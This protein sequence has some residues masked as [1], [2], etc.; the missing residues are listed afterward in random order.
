MSSFFISASPSSY[1]YNLCHEY[2]RQQAASDIT[3][4]QTRAEGKQQLQCHTVKKALQAATDF[5]DA[6]ECPPTSISRQQ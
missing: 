4:E 1:R 3:A 5:R 6:A 2:Y